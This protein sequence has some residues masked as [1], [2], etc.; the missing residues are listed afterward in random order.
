MSV[1]RRERHT[2]TH[3]DPDDVM[4]VT[5]KENSLPAPSTEMRKSHS[6]ALETVL[7]RMPGPSYE[8]EAIVKAGQQPSQDQTAIISIFRE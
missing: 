4:H 1:Q 8:A 6:M 2:H 5:T 7:G 3:T